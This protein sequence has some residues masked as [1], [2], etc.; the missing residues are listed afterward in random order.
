MRSAVLRRPTT[1]VVLTVGATLVAV[2]GTARPAHAVAPANDGIK[3]AQAVTLT[4]GTTF[5]ASPSNAGATAADDGAD[6]ILYTTDDAQHTLWYKFQPAAGRVSITVSSSDISEIAAGVLI[7]PTQDSSINGNTS[8]FSEI[9]D[10]NVE[11][12]V[13]G[14]EGQTLL[15]TNGT[16]DSETMSFQTDKEWVADTNHDYYL[17]IG[18]V[19]DDSSAPTGTINVS[20]TWTAA[21]TNDNFANATALTTSTSTYTGDNTAATPELDASLDNVDPYVDQLSMFS[22]WYKFTA[23]SDGLASISTASTS[24]PL[25]WEVCTSSVPSAGD[26]A[27]NDLLDSTGSS[28]PATSGSWDA[29]NGT[30]YYLF[31]DGL[32]VDQESYNAAGPYTLDFTFVNSPPNDDISA[33][34]KLNPTGISSV[35]GTNV[36]ATNTILGSNPP[37]TI[38]A[39]ADAGL[40]FNDGPQHS[41]FYEYRPDKSGHVVIYTTGP[42]N[43]DVAVFR[44]SVAKGFTSVAENDDYSAHRSFSRLALT[45]GSGGAYY[46]AVDGS[47]EVNYPEDT[48][49]LNLGPEPANDS[50]A[51][52]TMLAKTKVKIKG[53]KK[54]VSKGAGK[55]TGSTDFATFQSGEKNPKGYSGK[56]DVWYTFVAP[57]AGTYTFTGTLAD[58]ET[59]KPGAA[60]IAAYSGKGSSNLGMKLVKDASNPTSKTPAVIKLK[61][62]AGQVFKISVDGDTGAFGSYSLKW[63]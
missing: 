17:G 19:G 57:K 27:S 40:Y 42:L 61:A 33:A 59:G 22:V 20:I 50:L 55:V 2:L 62:K 58:V 46:I 5:T 34:Q 28:A 25:V 45:V 60:L 13:V 38:E 23:P 1:L 6:P 3:Q 47:S 24:F 37:A 56:A 16:D 54:T 9:V 44:G 31:L 29:V 14:Q 12:S 8:S 48:F 51:H 41:V 18:S 32:E 4:S 52:A 11:N 63:K 43:T 49:G 7:T 15:Y 30:T 26:C 35:T 21:P 36:G 39:E 53:K 10:D